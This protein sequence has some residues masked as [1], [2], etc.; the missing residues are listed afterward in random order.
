MFKKTLLCGAAMVLAGCVS[1]QVALERATG[2]NSTEWAAMNAPSL[3][4]KG[5]AIGVRGDQPRAFLSAACERSWQPLV[6][7]YTNGAFLRRGAPSGDMVFE[8]N[9]TPVEFI[10]AGEF[11]WLVASEDGYMD[12]LVAALRGDSITIDHG[13]GDR[14]PATTFAPTDVTGITDAVYNNCFV[15]LAVLDD[16]LAGF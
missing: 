13:L 5:T 6:L 8:V 2:L 12:I 10:E 1:Q 7:G 15:D 14:F 4:D 9:G 3:G 16:A 11:S